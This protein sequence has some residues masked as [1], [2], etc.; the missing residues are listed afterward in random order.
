MMLFSPPWEDEYWLGEPI[1]EENRSIGFHRLWYLDTLNQITEF[2]V[3]LQSKEG[4]FTKRVAWSDIKQDNKLRAYT[5]HRTLLDNEIVFDF[6]AKEFEQNVYH[7][8]T[9]YHLLKE[10]N[11]VPYV[12]YSGNKGLHAHFFLDYSSLKDT[13][14]M[15]L[16]IKI[17]NHFGSKKKFVKQFTT[18]IAKKLEKNYKDLCI[19]FQLNHTNHLIRSEGSMHKLGFKTFLGHTPE[20]VK[21]VPPIYNIENKGYPIFPFHDFCHNA[22][23]LKLTVPKDIVKLCKEFMQLKE[24]GKPKVRHANLNDFFTKPVAIATKP[25]IQFLLSQEYAK[26]SEGRKRALFILASHFKNDDD[27]IRKLKDWNDAVL[28]GYLQDFN[29]QTSAKSTTGKVSCKYT[30]EFLDS[31]G[32]GAVCKGCQQ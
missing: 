31:I 12:W 21:L 24:I 8:R 29:I 5:I 27:Q 9:I 1:Y 6:D 25:C 13:L 14:E 22:N 23:A 7:F 4:Y 20:E 16:Q 15:S 26:V 28:G 17:V 10:L 18:F 11:Y 2:N 19:D 30:H 32:C 3:S